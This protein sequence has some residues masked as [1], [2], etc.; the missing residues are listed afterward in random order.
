MDLVKE[1]EFHFLQP[2]LPFE[3]LAEGGWIGAPLGFTNGLRCQH[4]KRPPAQGQRALSHSQIVRAVVCRP[5]VR[6]AWAA[7]V[8]LSLQ[9]RLQWSEA[10]ALRPAFERE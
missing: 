3:F 7:C 10:L 4:A 1:T 2:D 5:V 6:S 8:R 9:R